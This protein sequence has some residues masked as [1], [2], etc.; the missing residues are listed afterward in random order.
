MKIFAIYCNIQLTK[1]PDWL[2][3]FKNKYNY[4]YDYHITLK[5]PTYI[6]EDEI[7]NVQNILSNIF[8]ELKIPNGQISLTFNKVITDTDKQGK[9][10]IMLNAEENGEINALQKKIVLALK[11]YSNFFYP[12]SEK[13][14]NGFNPHITIADELNDNQL[15]QAMDDIGNN[16]ECEAVV[17][18]VVLS[19]V[20]DMS[21]EEANNPENKTIYKLTNS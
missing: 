18:E 14:E 20:S 16:V 1:K 7:K 19:L 2:D 5:Q 13:W 15:K 8:N 6:E 4:S 9:S 10:L 21:A 12:E 17:K 3:D 11:N